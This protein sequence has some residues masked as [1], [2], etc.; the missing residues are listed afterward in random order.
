MILFFSRFYGLAGQSDLVLPGLIHMISLSGGVVEL[1]GFT[2]ALL[3]CLGEGAHHQLGCLDSPP[4]GL[5]SSRRLDWLPRLVVLV[6]RVKSEAVRPLDSYVPGIAK[7]HFHFILLV[8]GS[9][10]ASSSGVTP[11]HLETKRKKLSARPESKE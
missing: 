7:F 9:H 10:M 5:S 8:N 3:T 6:E 4:H 1:G 11:P 2:T